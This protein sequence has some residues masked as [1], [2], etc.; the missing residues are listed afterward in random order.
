[1]PSDDFPNAPNM[2]REFLNNRLVDPQQ[3]APKTPS[4]PH[5]QQDLDHLELTL[6]YTPGGQLEQD[7]HTQFSGNARREYNERM[8]K[9]EPPREDY[10][11]DQIQERFDKQIEESRREQQAQEVREE[12]VAERTEQSKAHQEKPQQE[13]QPAEQKSRNAPSYDMPERGDDASAPASPPPS[14]P[15]R[16]RPGRL[17]RDD[18]DRSG[19]DHEH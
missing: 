3:R 14:G 4:Q 17:G 1:M 5:Q 12:A 10:Y 18:R 13:K 8:Q 11:L 2:G 16:P 6:D 7:V 19:G 15:I 9:A